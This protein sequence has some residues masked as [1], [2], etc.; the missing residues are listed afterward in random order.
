M[1]WLSRFLG[2]LLP[3]SRKWQEND[4]KNEWLENL[5]SE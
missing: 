1:K 4:R 3:D 2:K 5:T